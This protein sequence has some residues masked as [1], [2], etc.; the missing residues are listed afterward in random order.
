[1]N[2]DLSEERQML[3]DNLRRFLRSS[4]TQ[5]MLVEATERSDGHSSQLWKGLVELGVPAALFDAG[6]GGFGGNGFDLSVVFE[7][8]GRAGVFEPLMESGILA[9]GLIA[10]L[11][12]PKQQEIVGEIISGRIV[13]LAHTEQ[14]GRYNLTHVATQAIKGTEGDWVLTGSKSLIVGAP[15]ADLALV[16]A[17]VSGSVGDPEGITLFLIPLNSEG[18]SQRSYPLNCGGRAAELRLERVVVPDDQRLGEIGGASSAIE[19]A[20]ARAA[21]AQCA[22]AVGLMEAIKDLTV[23]YLRT[24][25]QFG[26]PI[27][28]FQALQHR[29]A[30]LLIEIEQARSAAINACGHLDA[31]RAERERQVSAAKNLIGRVARLVVEE[32]IQMHGGIGMTKEYALGHLAKRLTMVDH[33]FGDSDFH[34]E[35]FMMLTAATTAALSM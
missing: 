31:P 24:R 27:G 10:S 19:D 16:S 11:G 18:L 26:Q 34:L 22:E 35:R 17:R 3:Q 32:A 21:A 6:V 13:T 23:E 4:V 8:I 1:M 28:K 9:G 29:M 25:K 12:T 30:D 14:G 33:R 5:D 20:H 7:E 2:F 15:A